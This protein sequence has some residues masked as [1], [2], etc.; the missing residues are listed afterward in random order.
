MRMTETQ[1]DA[2]VGTSDS[3]DDDATGECE[4][5]SL[6]TSKG[7]MKRGDCVGRR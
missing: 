1:N 4:L 5:R 7:V 2:S 3:P 6:P